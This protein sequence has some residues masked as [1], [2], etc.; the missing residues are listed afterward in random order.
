VIPSSDITSGKGILVCKYVCFYLFIDTHH[1]Y[2]NWFYVMYQYC[3]LITYILISFICGGGQV[4]LTT[5][6]ELVAFETCRV[7]VSNL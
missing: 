2:I 3:Y 4:V 5:Y 1:S 7:T 6:V